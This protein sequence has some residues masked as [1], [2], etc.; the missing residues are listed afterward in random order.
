MASGHLA[1]RWHYSS[2]T[3]TGKPERLVGLKG[4]WCEPSSARS[5]W[6]T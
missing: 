3:L 5:M 4:T 2:D 1:L 6:G